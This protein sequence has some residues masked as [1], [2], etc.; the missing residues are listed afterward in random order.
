VAALLVARL[1]LILGALSVVFEANSPVR[2]AQVVGHALRSLPGPGRRLSWL[3][4][5]AELS[6]RF[7]SFVRAESE[8]L[9]LAFA[10]RGFEAG[11]SRVWS[12]MRGYRL[13]LYPL[14]L[15]SFRRAEHVSLALTARGF[16]DSV[17]PTAFLQTLPRPGEIALLLAFV[18]LCLSA[19][20][21]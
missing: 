8:R 15:S 3:G 6:L 1:G 9:R 21:I 7:T 19:P 10:A 18:L 17:R 16:R 11:R 4:L 2:Y 12:R 13:I 20:W 14:L 5:L